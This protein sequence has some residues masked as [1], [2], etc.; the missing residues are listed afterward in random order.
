MINNIHNER[1]VLSLVVA[2]AFVSW[3]VFGGVVW[4]V[5]QVNDD[6]AVLVAEGARMDVENNAARSVSETLARTVD[7]RAKLA[8]YIIEG[9]DDVLVFIDV[10]ENIAAHAGV[11]LSL[12]SL[13]GERGDVGHALSVDMTVSGTWEHVLTF[14]A[15][16][17]TYPGNVEVSR[18]SV[19][20]VEV[21]GRGDDSSYWKADITFLV[22][23]YKE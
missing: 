20:Y 16:L 5:T 23:S 1:I 13:G 8:S 2:G 19:Q 11:T 9:D 4:G 3:I 14:I 12:R 10:L 22:K 18:V 6:I 15:L 7:T 17:E 21:E